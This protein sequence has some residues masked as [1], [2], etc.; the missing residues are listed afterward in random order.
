MRRLARP[1]LCALHC[2]DRLH[3]P[4]PHSLAFQVALV[5]H[6]VGL[7]GGVNSSVGAVVLHEK[8]GSAADVEIGG[9][10]FLRD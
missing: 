5:E 9:Q 7:H 8:V 1:R 2:L 3:D 6:G 10:L 4:Q